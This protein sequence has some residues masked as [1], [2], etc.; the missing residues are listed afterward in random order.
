MH[1]PCYVL[2]CRV[3]AQCFGNEW[4]AQNVQP[5]GP[6]TWLLVICQPDE[7]SRLFSPVPCLPHGMVMKT[8][9][10]WALKSS[11]LLG[12]R[13]ESGS[14]QRCRGPS[15]QQSSPPPRC[16]M[17]AN[18]RSLHKYLREPAPTRI[19]PCFHCYLMLSCISE[20][21]RE[22]HRNTAGMKESVIREHTKNAIRRTDQN[23]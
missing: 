5:A 11:E 23:C 15:S 2:R 1:A 10:T 20:A 19:R 22:S 7:T 18:V 4:P 8:D 12:S 16:G 3:A 17:L 6:T 13:G 14:D 21:W 9:V